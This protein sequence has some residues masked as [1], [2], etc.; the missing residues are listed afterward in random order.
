MMKI[1]L[2]PNQLVNAYAN[3][4][5]SGVIQIS[6]ILWIL[7]NSIKF[8]SVQDR[9]FFLIYRLFDSMDYF[10]LLFAIEFFSSCLKEDFD[11]F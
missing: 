4:T 8:S 7:V 2:G 1:K 9:I 11:I 3:R 10:S 5:F 6:N